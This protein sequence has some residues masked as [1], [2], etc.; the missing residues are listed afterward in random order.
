MNL[1][2]VGCVEETFDVHSKQKKKKIKLFF[3]PVVAEMKNYSS[4]LA[5]PKNSNERRKT[6]LRAAQ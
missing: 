6:V 1:K 3:G 5:G 2:R 4:L